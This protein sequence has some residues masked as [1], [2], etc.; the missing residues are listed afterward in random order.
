MCCA[1][2]SIQILQPKQ[3][4]VWVANGK[5]RRVTFT[6][7]DDNADNWLVEILDD[8]RQIVQS[9]PADILLP[10]KRGERMVYEKHVIV[11]ETLK[12]GD[13]RLRVCGMMN[14]KKNICN[15][16]NAFHIEGNQRESECSILFELHCRCCYFLSSSSSFNVFFL[17]VFLRYPVLK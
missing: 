14:D 10:E 8:E 5:S 17:I 6:F 15:E 1:D 11:P 9:Y 2:C 12:S 7:I 16:T 13:H 4:S 3:T